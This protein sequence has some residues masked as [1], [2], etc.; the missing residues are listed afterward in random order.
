[1]RETAR[2]MRNAREKATNNWKKTATI[3][4][5]SGNVIA[6][7]AVCHWMPTCLKVCSSV[8]LGMVFD[9]RLITLCFR[10]TQLMHIQTSVF[11]STSSMER[12]VKRIRTLQIY[13]TPGKQSDNH[14]F[15]SIFVSYFVLR[16]VCKLPVMLTHTVNRL[17]TIKKHVAAS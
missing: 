12:R 13:C 6:L 5:I 8:Q 9:A 4:C 10:Y 1:M 3:F 16:K 2:K 11:C 17:L 7:L 15:T 14:F